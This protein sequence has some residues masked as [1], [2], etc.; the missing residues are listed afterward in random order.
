MPASVLAA[1]A[2]GSTGIGAHLDAGQDVCA[3][4]LRD[5]G[6]V[7]PVRLPDPVMQEALH[8]YHLLQHNQNCGA[9]KGAYQGEEACV[10]P[11]L[12]VKIAN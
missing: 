7:L 2:T 12:K 6:G 4:L 8:S 11:S 10:V 3:A 5:I 1:A 9:Q